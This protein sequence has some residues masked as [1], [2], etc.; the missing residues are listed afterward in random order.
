MRKPA[1]VNY[2]EENLYGQILMGKPLWANSSLSEVINGLLPFPF[3]QYLF[4]IY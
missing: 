1:P 2:F 3:V 4:F